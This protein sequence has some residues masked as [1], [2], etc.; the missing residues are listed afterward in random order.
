V[1]RYR[2]KVLGICTLISITWLPFPYWVFAW[3]TASTFVSLD[4]CA[5]T[6]LHAGP[7]HTRA[8]D[9]SAPLVFTSKALHQEAH[10][11]QKSWH[12]QASNK[13]PYLSTHGPQSPK[14]I[15]LS[16]QRRGN[17]ARLHWR[18][19]HTAWH[20]GRIA[21]YGHYFGLEKVKCGAVG[22]SQRCRWYMVVWKPGPWQQFIRARW[23]EARVLAIIYCAKKNTKGRVFSW[24]SWA[25]CAIGG[26]RNQSTR[27][28]ALH[29]WTDSYPPSPL[30]YCSWPISPK[31]S[32]KAFEFRSRGN[33]VKMGP[34]GLS[35]STFEC[36]SPQL[37]IM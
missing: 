20:Q 18:T 7:K 5:R 27:E 2:C 22:W 13:V 37:L 11:R 26:L 17:R 28:A 35:L 19:P 30:C 33:R 31:G 10:K 23:W 9:S 8:R 34:K 14:C 6:H 3:W 4:R 36:C 12:M 1:K 32:W 24:D 25:G 21:I 29:L 15:L 16:S